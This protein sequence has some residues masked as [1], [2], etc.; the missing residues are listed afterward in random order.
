MIS[1][2]LDKFSI[3]SKLNVLEIGSGTNNPVLVLKMGINDKHGVSFQTFGKG[4]PS[5]SIYGADIGK[6]ILFQTEKIKHI[7]WT[8]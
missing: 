2:I 8:N 6:S 3:N 7:M 4:L 1:F 5:G